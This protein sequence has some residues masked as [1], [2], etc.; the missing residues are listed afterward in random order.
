MKR[1]KKIRWLALPVV[2]TVTMSACASGATAPTVSGGG[3]DD[4]TMTT[5]VIESW[6]SDDTVQWEDV[7]IPAFEEAHPNI[8]VEFN[9][10]LSTEYDTSL[11]S[12]M[13]AGTA[14][15]I[16]ACR[17]FDVSLNLFTEG[18]LAALND[19]PGIENFSQTALTAWQTDD[20]S[21][22][23]CVPLASVVHGF[24]Y[25]KD[26]FDELGLE[27]PGT[28]SEFDAVLDAIKADG[29]YAPMVL[30]VKGGWPV[31]LNGFYSVGVLSLIHI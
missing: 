1:T 26:I 20:Q 5:L 24:F 12:K 14:G 2:L 10:T 17:P 30:G 22:T 3:G 18:D 9:P 27:V 6:R 15:D 29:T 19:L 25:N 31:A 4:D 13:T 8:N 11:A 7:L 21:D 16:V 28:R 23:F